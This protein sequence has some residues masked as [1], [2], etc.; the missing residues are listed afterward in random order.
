MAN[1][2]GV[3]QVT[4]SLDE[5]IR[6]DGVDVIASFVSVDQNQRVCVAAARAGKH[7]FSVKPLARTT[8]EVTE[9]VR[10]MPPVV[11]MPAESTSRVAAQTHAQRMDRRGT[12]WTHPDRDPQ[13]A[14]GAADDAW[15][16]LAAC[17]AFYQGA[18]AG[19]SIMPEHEPK[20][21]ANSAIGVERG[22]NDEHEP[23]HGTTRDRR[24]QAR[25]P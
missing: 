25:R 10:A 13:P 7:I 18:A 14:C 9:V 24:R 19:T 21:A 1:H 15:R 5:L 6:E 16:N 4:T 17:T 11:F 22:A 2:L 3:E 20:D 12:I 23:N 8:E